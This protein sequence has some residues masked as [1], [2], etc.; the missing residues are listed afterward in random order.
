MEMV[1]PWPLPGETRSVVWRQAWE[2]LALVPSGR[3][4]DCH[5]SSSCLRGIRSAVCLVDQGR[6]SIPGSG[7]NMCKGAEAGK[8]DIRV[9]PQ[10]LLF[11]LSSSV[12][13]Q[14]CYRLGV[15]LHSFL[16]SANYVCTQPSSQPT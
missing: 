16:I 6:A 5:I 8:N 4:C 9:I 11:H 14:S 1:K 7:N 3:C 2:R 13:F 12:G 10:D 15:S